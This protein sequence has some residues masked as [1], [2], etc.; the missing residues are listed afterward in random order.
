MSECKYVPKHGAR[1][2][3]GAL[4]DSCIGIFSFQPTGFVQ[5]TC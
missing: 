4:G 2:S 1:E 5:A 3:P